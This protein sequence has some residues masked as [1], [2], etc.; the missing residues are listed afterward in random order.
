MIIKREGERV[1]L[2]PEDYED[3]VDLYLTI[4]PGEIV[5]A[6]A[7]LVIKGDETREKK[8]VKRYV[9]L[10]V[11]ELALEPHSKALRIR[12]KVIQGPKEIPLTR[13]AITL[14]VGDSLET[15][16]KEEFNEF[17]QNLRK[18]YALA[19]DD[20]VASIAE[21][22]RGS[23]KILETIYRNERE[24]E[25]FIGEVVGKLR[26]L[27]PENLIICGPAFYKELVKKQFGKGILIETSYGGELGIR[28]L[29]KRREFLEKINEIRE[30]EK[31]ERL[32]E[33]LLG[34]MKETSSVGEEAINDLESGNVEEIFI[35]RDYLKR[36]KENRDL[37]KIEKLL[38]LPKQ[39]GAKI[40]IIEGESDLA[41]QLYFL[42]GVLVKKRW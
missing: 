4:N 31:L 1:K 40:Y 26:Q 12:G 9:C 36:L 14:K 41:K 5:C 17:R 11:E 42:G 33:A 32:N 27:N 30:V 22:Y 39:Y 13:L 3:L 38:K 25:D 29:L 7:T 21:I 35:S 8:K 23:Y 28:E 6:K 37:E 15:E 24:L 18:V 10:E 19:I 16:W 2:I 20:R 34:L